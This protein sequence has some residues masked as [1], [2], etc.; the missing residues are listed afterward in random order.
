M[1]AAGKASSL[2]SIVVA[3]AAA[4]C[5][6]ATPLQA[7]QSKTANA[8]VA[9]TTN[10]KAQA[11]GS[12]P[13]VAAGPV[14]KPGAPVAPA[15]RPK[16]NPPPAPVVSQPPQ[17]KTKLAPLPPIDTST[18]PPTLPRATRERMRTCAEEWDKKKRAASAALPMWRDFAAGCLTR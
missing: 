12:A 9:A 13:T 5:A 17:A 3:G 4:Y 14:N 16:T 8:L 10:R 11:S 2:A 6:L 7:P 15:P 18:P 1:A